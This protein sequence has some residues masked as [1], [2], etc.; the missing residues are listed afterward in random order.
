MPSSTAESSIILVM[1]YTLRENKDQID[2]N[3][4]KKNHQMDQPIIFNNDFGN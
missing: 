4:N 2:F 3:K 1:S